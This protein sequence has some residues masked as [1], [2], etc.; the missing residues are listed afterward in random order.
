[1][2]GKKQA[3]LVKRGR[4]II[5]GA[6]YE[7][8]DVGDGRGIYVDFYDSDNKTFPYES[9]SK[10]FPVD[11]SRLMVDGEMI[12]SWPY[13]AIGGKAIRELGYEPVEDEWDDGEEE[14]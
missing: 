2:G 3:R 4:D 5:T 10:A 6:P 14:W 8:W 1:M 12:G 9:G 13:D 7:I 11:M